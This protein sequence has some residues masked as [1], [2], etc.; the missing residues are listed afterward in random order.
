MKGIILAG[1]SGTRLYP[2]TIATS[3]QL[4]PLYDKPMIYYP[5]STLML[6][7]I[8]E[9]LMITTPQD[10][11]NFK[12]LL[13]D[14]SQ[15]GISIEYTIQENPNGLAEAFILGEEFIGDDA[16][17]LILGDNF[18]YGQHFSVQV[19]NAAKYVEENKGGHIFGS[20]VNDPRAYGVVEF[21]ENKNVVSIEEKPKMPKSNYAVPGLYVFDSSVSSKA[22]K[23][24]PSERGEL[25]ITSVIDAYLKE[26]NLKVEL[27]GRGMAWLDTGTHDD[28]LEAA[29]FVKTVQ[30]R[31]G[32]LVGSPE[33]IAFNFGWISKEKM[34][35]SIKDL[36]KNKYGQTLAKLIK[37]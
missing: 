19:Q 33:E 7:G 25:E 17:T 26:S 22:K 8:K 35:D 36:Q 4:M 31:Q 18:F 16:V 6:M 11:P 23:V 9:V 21:D 34:Q 10:Q 2:L 3:K 24:V 20:L 32:L 13:G 12:K 28:L 14:G 29:N 1:G 5:L 15:F 30:D 27:F 37:E